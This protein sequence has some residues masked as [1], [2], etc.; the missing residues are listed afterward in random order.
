MP[1]NKKSLGALLLDGIWGENPLF[2][3]A[4][5]ICPALA[6]ATTGFNGLAIGLA[7]GAV[8]VCASL[9][10]SI[11]GKLVEGVFRLPVFMVVTA[12]LATLAQMVLKAYFPEIN[13]ALGLFVP[14]MAASTLVLVRTETFSGKVSP[15]EAVVDGIGMGIGYACALALLGAIREVFAY[16]S[17][18]NDVVF[19]TGFEANAMAMLPAGGFMLLGL[20]MGVYNLAA[21]RRKKGKE[22]AN[23]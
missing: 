23:A 11:L 1:E 6:V 17:F 7:T 20:L 2:R 22:D 18:F 4:L 9:V 8:L 21:G 16:G 13:A 14:L 10:I 19:T 12:A 5:G 3:L 15:V